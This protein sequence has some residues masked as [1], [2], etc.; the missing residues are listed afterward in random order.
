VIIRSI[1][2]GAYLLLA[3]ALGASAGA[4][5]LPGDSLYQLPIVLTTSTGR[6]L[7]LSE[8]RGK[9]LI[10]TMFYGNCTGVCP[11][12]TTRLQHIVK[13]LTPGERARIRVLM[14]SFDSDRDTP[15]S[16]AAFASEHAIDG[17]NWLL[18]RAPAADVR[19][20]AAALRIKYRELADH[21]FNHSAVFSV[22]DRDGVV[23]AR[24]EELADSNGEFLR[25]VRTQI[26]GPR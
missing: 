25:A 10:V 23:R 17:K 20:L 6:S 1:A 4:A 21:S 7:Q 15:A 16:L 13:K 14:V 2:V 11:L 22:T 18:A 8:L 5:V 24:T 9:P 12:L 26:A 19:S 3:A